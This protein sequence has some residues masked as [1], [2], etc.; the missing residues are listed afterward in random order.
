M[1]KCNFKTCKKASVL[2]GDCKYC[3]GN[4]CN[5]HRIVE[6]HLCKNIQQCKVKALEKHTEKIM[7]GKCVGIKIQKV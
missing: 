1:A 3:Q 2:I 6:Q 7:S 4:F 5:M